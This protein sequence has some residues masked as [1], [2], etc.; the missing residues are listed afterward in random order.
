MHVA[1]EL[2]G[3]AAGGRAGGPDD[4]CQRD[5]YFVRGWIGTRPESR[6][7][8]EAIFLIFYIRKFEFHGNFGK[9]MQ[10][11]FGGSWEILCIVKTTVLQVFIKNLRI[12]CGTS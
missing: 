8:L 2:P 7:T 6:G 12:F 5:F 3:A 1:A 11:N 9:S 10:E 4:F